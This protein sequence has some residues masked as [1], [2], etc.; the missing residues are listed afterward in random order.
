MI[1]VNYN[2]L[3]S[4]LRIDFSLIF[5]YFFVKNNEIPTRFF[6]ITDR[7]TITNLTLKT[8]VKHLNI[9]FSTYIVIVFLECIKRIN[10]KNCIW[11]NYKNFF[12]YFNL[13]YIFI[14]HKL[15]RFMHSIHNILTKSQY[16]KKI[17]ASERIV[18]TCWFNFECLTLY[19]IFNNCM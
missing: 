9:F 5:R 14:R 12:E 3:N 6:I 1:T 18:E 16:D 11:N 15:D 19:I 13:F 17:C 10:K 4:I 8:I 2:N 7:N